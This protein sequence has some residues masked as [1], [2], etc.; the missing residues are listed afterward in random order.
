MGLYPYAGED[1]PKEEAPAAPKAVPIRGVRTITEG[2]QRFLDRLIAEAGRTEARFLD[3]FG[4]AATKDLP[5]VDF[6]RAMK[7]LQQAKRR[8]A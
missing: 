8:A 1:L 6:D 7:G 2:Q 5:M 3:Y 4:L